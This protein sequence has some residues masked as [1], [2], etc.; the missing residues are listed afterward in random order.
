MK[1]FES[2][3]RELLIDRMEEAGCVFNF[4]VFE[5]KSEMVVDEFVHRQALVGLHEQLMKEAWEWHNDLIKNSLYESN[6]IPQISWEL[7]KAV[8]TPLSEPELKSLML[9]EDYVRG[10]LAL[11]GHFREPPYGTK[12]KGENWRHRNFLVSGEAL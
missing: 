7:E 9:T 3:R 5:L 12:F 1:V 6:V 2:E 8:A 4:I 10:P 11:Y